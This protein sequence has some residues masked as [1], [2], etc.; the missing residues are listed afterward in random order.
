MKDGSSWSLLYT[1]KEVRLD[2]SKGVCSHLSDASPSF[3]LSVSVRLLDDASL[4]SSQACCEVL[5]YVM[6][7]SFFLVFGTSI[8][9][10]PKNMAHQRY[11]SRDLLQ[12]Y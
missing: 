7:S 4:I 8:R 9:E 3:P 6:L 12:I 2:A 5:S 10:E 1:S 11:F